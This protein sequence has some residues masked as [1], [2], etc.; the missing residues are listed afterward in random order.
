M[1]GIELK[2]VPKDPWDLVYI[3]KYTI[4]EF[5]TLGTGKGALG[6]SEIPS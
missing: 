1:A 2:P 5:F 4:H 3:G 6:A